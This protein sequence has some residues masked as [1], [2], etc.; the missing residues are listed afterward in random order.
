V[1]CCWS[2]QQP[3]RTFDIRAAIITPAGTLA[4]GWPAGGATI[5]S[6]D[7]DQRRP[8]IAVD[9]PGNNALAVW[10]D[11]RSGSGRDVYAQLIV[12]SGPLAVPTPAPLG[13]G[14]AIGVLHPNPASGPF[15]FVLTLPEAR[16]ARLEL[17][18]IAGRIVHEQEFAPGRAGRF[19]FTLDADAPPGVYLLRVRQGSATQSARLVRVE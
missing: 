15:S 9:G 2:D 6:A 19:P 11:E 3:G 7:L 13:A 12:A 5:C 14:P 10:E 16:P 8:V 4:P 17:L 1:L 18:D